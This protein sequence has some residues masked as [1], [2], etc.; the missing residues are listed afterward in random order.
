M[1]T[2][3]EAAADW[4]FAVACPLS[5]VSMFGVG[6]YL[7]R[8]RLYTLTQLRCCMFWPFLLLEYRDHTNQTRGRVGLWYYWTIISILTSVG[9]ILLLLAFQI[10]HLIRA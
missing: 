10:A 2:A 3:I 4:L 5:I 1:G 8:E 7:Y 6:D 9:A